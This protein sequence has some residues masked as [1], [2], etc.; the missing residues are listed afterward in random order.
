[1]PTE[2]STREVVQEYHHAWQAGEI[3]TATALLAPDFTNL[4][5]I[6]DYHSIAEYAQ[7]LG[8]FAR[9]VTHLEMISELYGEN[10]ATLIYDVQ[11]ATPVGKSRIAEHFRLTDGKISTIITIFDATGWRTK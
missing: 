8:Q 1:M 10:E 11:L 2:T 3:A 7:A 4:T 6:N 5:S 9:I